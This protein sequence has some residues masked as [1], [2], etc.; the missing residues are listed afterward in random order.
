[1]TT[2]I[3]EKL[4]MADKIMKL[5]HGKLERGSDHMAIIADSAIKLVGFL[6]EK[7]R[8]ASASEKAKKKKSR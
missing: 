4:E 2:S 6:M 1:M 3:R 5:V 7:Q 8:Q